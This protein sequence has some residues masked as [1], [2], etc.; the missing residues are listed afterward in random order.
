MRE[1][2]LFQTLNVDA[3]LHGVQHPLRAQDG[4]PVQEVNGGYWQERALCA[5]TD[6]EEFFPERGGTAKAAK[7]V[8]NAC[9]VRVE[10]LEDALEK[11]DRFGVAGGLSER[12]RR[13]LEKTIEGSEDTSA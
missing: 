12:E 4:A 1:L 7:A 11:K 5:Q 8:C 10:C 13:K 6:P 2:E 9:E 3:R